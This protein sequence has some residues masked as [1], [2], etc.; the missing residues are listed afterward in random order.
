MFDYGRERMDTEAV[1]FQ[2]H[3]LPGKGL[4]PEVL[5]KLRLPVHEGMTPPGGNRWPEKKFQNRSIKSGI[6]K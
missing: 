1:C 6:L 2:L 3:P 5:E 4:Q